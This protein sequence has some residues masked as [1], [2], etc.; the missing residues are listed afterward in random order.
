[1]GTPA[2]FYNNA[3]DLNRYSNKVARQ[4]ITTY[5]DVILD[6]VGQLQGLD[7]MSAPMRAARLRGILRD[8]KQSID[9]WAG[10][11]TALSVKELQ[12]LAELQGEF[13]QEQLKKALPASARDQVRS[14]QISQNFAQSVA[15]TDPTAI[16][17][18]ALS[19][20]LQAAVTGAPA[21]FQ[22]TAAQGATVTLPNGKV[23]EKSFRGLAES[24][25]EMFGRVVRT[26]LVQG[27]SIQRIS[28]ELKG[29]LRFGQPGSARQIALAGGEVTKLAN[30]QVLTLVRT[31]VNQVANAA[32]QANYQANQNVT[33]KYKYTATLDNRTSPICRSLDG[34]EFEYGKGPTPPQHFNCRSTTVP[35]IDYKGLKLEPPPR[36]DVI[37]DRKT[38]GEWLADQSKE[39]KASILGSERRAEIFDKFT[40]KVGPKE[41]IRRF[42][43][44][45][46][47]ELDL[48]GLER[49]LERTKAKPIAPVTPKPKT[50][51]GPSA[52]DGQDAARAWAEGKYDDMTAAQYAKA[53]AD[54]KSIGAYGKSRAD[55]YDQKFKGTEKKL[56]SKQAGDLDTAVRNS[57]DKFEG[58]IYRG[59]GLHSNA[60]VDDFLKSLDGEAATLASWTRSQTTAAEFASGY[61]QVTGGPITHRVIVRRLNKDGV[62]IEKLLPKGGTKYL[63]NIAEKEVLMPSGVRTQV[64]KVQRIKKKDQFGNSY[65]QVLVDLEDAPIPTTKTAKAK[66]AKGVSG[67]ASNTPKQG[68]SPREYIQAHQHDNGKNK[69]SHK[70]IADSLELA[71]NEKGLAGENMRKML[72]FQ[73][74]K[75]IQTIWSTGREKLIGPDF[76]HWGDSEII[77]ALRASKGKGE[78]VA[79]AIADDLEKGRKNPLLNKIGKVSSGAAGHTMEGA[80]LIVL[81]QEGQFKQITAKS[82]SRIKNAAANSV[83]DAKAG[84]P[85]KV[86][87]AQLYKKTGKTT[88]KTEDGWLGTYV[89][90]MG[91]QVHF[92]AGRP[93]LGRI[94]EEGLEDLSGEKLLVERGK[95]RWKPSVYGGTNEMEQ[96]AETFVQFVFAPDELRKANPYAYRWVAEAM[97]AALK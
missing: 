68:P 74:K 92:K 33:K 81:K 82:I 26:G 63:G 88:W 65:T 85:Q 43:R 50:P 1:M 62:A 47:S 54:G 80:N 75:E 87:T 41:A 21:T 52:Q 13:V 37:P 29:R 45:D 4:V 67:P 15:V 22:L 34:K 10:D 19:D 84:R 39:R 16:N 95:R 3:V 89:H 64:A 18:V 73:Q 30:H 71:G 8:M 51:R 58:K 83:L 2:A 7:E 66:V 56:L 36:A 90:E 14:V 72:Q 97:E 59:V 57:K 32:S 91:H 38:Y 70:A 5:N 12:G 46:G 93:S 11:A 94:I 17:V 55:Y 42:V 61:T 23:L 96:F 48:A 49:R 40:K 9:G 31:S 86:V 79:R 60:E 25:A 35:V 24:N 69:L 78:G 6:A 20:D 76:D 27:K 77:K 44:E 53:K 28:R